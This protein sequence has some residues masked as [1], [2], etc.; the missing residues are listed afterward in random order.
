MAFGKR[1]SGLDM[2]GLSKKGKSRT[3]ARSPKN[4]GLSFAKSAKYSRSTTPKKHGTALTK[5]PII[6]K[7]LLA[8]VLIAVFALLLA[9]FVG[10]IVYKQTIK[11]SIRPNLNTTA[12]K[13]VLVTPSESA[14]TFWVA[15]T[16]T[17]AKSSLSE[18]TS[19]KSF[20]I[21]HVD[22][23]NEEVALLWI[24]I[25]TRMYLEGSGYVRLSDLYDSKGETGVVEALCSL[26]SIDIAHYIEFSETGLAEYAASQVEIKLPDSSISNDEIVKKLLTKIVGSSSEELENQV[27][28]FDKY[29][30]S[31]MSHEDLLS[32]FTKLQ[33]MEVDDNYASGTMP[34]TNKTENSID[35]AVPKSNSWK[36]MVERVANGLGPIASKKEVSNNKELR[37]SNKVTIWNGAGVT[38]IAA[39]CVNQV[40]KLGWKVK[41]SGNAAQFVYE[42]TLI[43]YKDD[44]KKRAAKLLV[45]DLGQGR[46]VPSAYR[47]SFDGDLLIVV[48]K[49]YMPY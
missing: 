34:Y 6:N 1:N 20:A 47:Y 45:S 33:G 41:S 35:Y 4:S 19:A 3:L 37:S 2:S 44:S 48:G 30:A 26:A 8:I 24:P 38:G 21:C 28:V 12:L 11:N 17:D 46:T 5:S 23:E 9:G 42:E 49:D 13:S 10:F 36:T 43:V 31:D 32:I 14:T 15:L 16:Q 22:L 27:D 39:D 18:G 7:H 29:F 25:N 40:K